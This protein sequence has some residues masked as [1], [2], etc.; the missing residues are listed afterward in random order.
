[1]PSLPPSVLAVIE[2]DRSRGVVV[3]PLSWPRRRVGRPVRRRH[4]RTAGTLL[5]RPLTP[6]LIRPSSQPGFLSTAAAAGPFSASCWRS[7]SRRAPRRCRRRHRLLG[8]RDPDRFPQGDVD[9]VS[10]DTDGRVTIAPALQ[11]LATS[12][13]P[14]CGGSPRRDGQVWAA[15]GHDG[16]LWS[17]PAQTAAEVRVRR[18]GAGSPGHRGRAAG[19]GAGRLVARRQGLP[20]RRGRHATTF[21]D[22]EDK[23]IWAIAVAPDGTIYVGTGDKGKVYKVPAAAAPARC[24]TTRHRARQ[25][26]GL[27]RDGRA[28]RRHSTPGRVVR[29]DAEGKPFVILEAG[30][31]E[32]QQPAR[33]R[34][35][36]LRHGPRARPPP[37]RP[38]RRRRPRHRRH[39]RCGHDVAPR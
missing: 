33:R 2:C 18:R 17:F 10:I 3:Q 21:F 12:A 38:R 35:R 27:R 22:P 29:L 7:A 34:R 37:R 13:R 25:R 1:M 30:Y 5:G 16:K 14:S 28:A 31:E 24:S 19:L 39:Q 32:V 23:Y 36:H 6:L 4:H 15:T 11:V 9:A 20:R 8:R 26:A